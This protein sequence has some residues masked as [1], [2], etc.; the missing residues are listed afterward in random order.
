MI[1]INIYLLYLFIKLSTNKN[2]YFI[3]VVLLLW[4]YLSQSLYTSDTINTNINNN[5]VKQKMIQ[6]EKCQ[7]QWN[8]KGKNP[9]YAMCPRCR[10]LDKLP[11]RQNENN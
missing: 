5:E 11:M 7:Y 2:K 3:C 8:Y 4:K 6:C 9:F 10:H 1:S